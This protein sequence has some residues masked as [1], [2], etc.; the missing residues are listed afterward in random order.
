M[1]WT[2]FLK[3]KGLE[4]GT[5]IRFGSTNRLADQHIIQE[6]LRLKNNKHFDEQ[7]NFDCPMRN[8]RFDITEQLFIPKKKFTEKTA[9]SLELIVQHQGKPFPSNGAVLLFADNPR[10]FFPD[11][12][13]R[14][15]RFLG[16]T[17]TE[18]IDHK[19]LEVPL[20]TALDHIVMFIQRH[21]SIGAKI[22]GTRRQNIRQ[23]PLPVIRE[24]VINSLLHADYSMKGFSITVAIFDDRIEV[25]NP[26]A[27]PLGLSL[28]AALSGIS[29]LRN[30]VIGRVFRE[31][32]LIEQWGSGLKRMIE[33]C[34]KQ[35]IRPPKFEELGNFFRTTLYHSP[36]LMAME[37]WELVLIEYLHKHKEITP[38]Q[39]Q[40]LWKVSV[41]TTATR[42]GKMYQKELVI[43]IATSAFDPYKKFILPSA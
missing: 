37:K 27:L 28:E 21:T 5:L 43:E 8:I 23:Y 41:R 31:L 3:A 24:A 16:T 36:R 42:L 18:I 13:V 4:L 30:R 6:I 11:A 26:G 14:L 7:P 20:A 40:V 32:D 29:Q 39:A 1:L 10:D 15:G 19:D 22:E 25:T 17:K 33:I 2:L 9:Q 38:K 35:N 12:I 34:T